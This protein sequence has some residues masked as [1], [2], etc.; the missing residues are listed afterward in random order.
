MVKKG[1]FIGQYGMT[2]EL[3]IINYIIEQIPAN[4]RDSAYRHLMYFGSRF[5]CW[6]ELQISAALGGGAW[7]SDYLE[8][9]LLKEFVLSHDCIPL[10]DR[11]LPATV[12]KPDYYKTA[13]CQDEDENKIF[14]YYFCKRLVKL[15][16]FNHETS[17]RYDRILD[18]PDVN[19]EEGVEEKR[20]LDPK[21]VKIINDKFNLE[22][23]KSVYKR[24]DII[25]ALLLE[26]YELNTIEKLKSCF[27]KYYACT[28]RVIESDPVNFSAIILMPPQNTYNIHVANQWFQAKGMPVSQDQLSE[29]IINYI[30]CYKNNYM[31]PQV[32]PEPMRVTEPP[33]KK[34]YPYHA[35]NMFNW[36]ICKAGDTEDETIEKKCKW[37]E[38]NKRLKIEKDTVSVH[39]RKSAVPV[40]KSVRKRTSKK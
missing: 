23:E 12:E 30:R 35:D 14:P 34:K 28:A 25:S 3:F 18:P 6:K 10:P 27:I 17:V 29:S 26:H 11:N 5:G 16:T 22:L 15:N 36:K 38:S 1:N 40:R 32:L 2:S 8:F 31:N 39:V 19:S 24:Q 9:K 21:Q 4:C 37:L 7:D 33:N 20:Q 13:K